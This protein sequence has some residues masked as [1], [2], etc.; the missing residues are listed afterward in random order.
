MFV[1]DHANFLVKV[2]AILGV[3]NC[4]TATTPAH[5]VFCYSTVAHILTP[6]VNLAFRPKSDFKNKCQ[7]LSQ[8]CVVIFTGASKGRLKE[9]IL[10]PPIVKIY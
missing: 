9:Y 3:I 7:A 10:H 2:F 5:N 4:I 1:P 8:L 6:S